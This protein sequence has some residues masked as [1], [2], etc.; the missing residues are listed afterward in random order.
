M[1]A[2]LVASQFAPVPA[3]LPSTLAE[4]AGQL[5]PGA[6]VTSLGTPLVHLRLLAG[7]ADGSLPDNPRA[8]AELLRLRIGAAFAAAGA[9]LSD[10][11]T[12]RA[13]QVGGHPAVT[14]TGVAGALGPVLDVLLA[15]ADAGVVTELDAM[16]GQA[17]LLDEARETRSTPRLR[18]RELCRV[19]SDSPA[20]TAQLINEIR[21]ARFETT[22]V[23]ESGSSGPSA[24]G[25]V[26]EP[27]PSTPRERLQGGWHYAGASESAQ[28]WCAYGWDLQVS[29]LREAAAAQLFLFSLAG[30]S[31]SWLYRR[32]RDELG[33]S[34]GPRTNIQPL[35]P[36]W[37]R[38]WLELNVPRQKEAIAHDL[39]QQ[40]LH[41]DDNELIAAC[42][43]SSKALVT[44]HLRTL[45]DAA[46]QADA[47]CLGRRIGS[48]RHSW[49]LVD[50][51]A[52]LSGPD[53]AAATP[54]ALRH[55]GKATV[56]VYRT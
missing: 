29:S 35:G 18:A 47:I 10:G 27:V 42:N 8:V 9:D 23:I 39:V 7:R 40:A 32:L 55:P 12:T 48:W 50:V 5:H 28:S 13:R 33:L 22:L 19:P 20:D 16:A 53:I 51:L 45:D 1:T 2:H 25:F 14:L 26:D 17:V 49:D 38:C 6:W 30:T 21:D 36:G 41:L 54:T 44:A 56:G 31:S 3:D 15:M 24:G 52:Q 11:V 43:Q 46:G 34:Y 37:I 4:R